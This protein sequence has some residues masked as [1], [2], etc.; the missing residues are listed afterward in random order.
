MEPSNTEF[1]TA[2]TGLR[3]Q[4][5]AHGLDPNTY[6]MRAFLVEMAHCL[7]QERANSREAY[8]AL[9]KRAST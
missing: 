7:A 6:Q 4:A 8:N 2:L 1:A 5:V 9:H 3:T